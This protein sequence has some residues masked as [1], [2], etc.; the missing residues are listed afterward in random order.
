MPVSRG[1][2]WTAVVFVLIGMVAPAGCGGGSSASP[3]PSPSSMS[4]AQLQVL[5]NN[6]VQCIRQHG[7]PGMPDIPVREGRVVVPDENTVDSATR[8]NAESARA[9]CKAVEDRIPA[10]ALQNGNDRQGVPNAADVPKM[11]QFAQ[12]MRQ[13]GVPGWPDPRAD[14]TFPGADQIMAQGKAVVGPKIR[15]CQKYYDGP[16]RFSS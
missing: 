16:I 12:C 7:A 6:L 14:G 8:R 5:V 2:R 10:T 13:N 11:R 4:D 3:S 1:G 15:V 9:A